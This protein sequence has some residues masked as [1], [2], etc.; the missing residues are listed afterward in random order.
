MVT[1]A[2][3]TIFGTVV[4]WVLGLFP[5]ISLPS[6]LTAT[7]SGTVN[8]TMTSLMTSL[9]SFDAFL[10]VTQVIAAGA[11]VLAALFLA[12]TLRVI[13]IAASFFT[14]GGGM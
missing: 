8:G 3:V 13:R 6:Y 5:T 2:I 14:L 9:W 7:G 4:T 11:L 1:N 10:P 12:V